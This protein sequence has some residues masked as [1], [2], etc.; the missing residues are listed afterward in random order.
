M[1]CWGI[2]PT[3]AT[4]ALSSNSGQK[5]DG[6]NSKEGQREEEEEEK[7]AATEHGVCMKWWEGM[8]G[9]WH[10][11]TQL[12]DPG[13]QKKFRVV[14][15]GPWAQVRASLADRERANRRAFMT[16]SEVRKM[17]AFFNKYGV[18]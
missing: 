16:E 17:Q 6:P 1:T 12:V 3:E 15:Q 13:L 8:L 4:A 14:N 9:R 18:S 2:T 5:N 7:V 10:E 11:K